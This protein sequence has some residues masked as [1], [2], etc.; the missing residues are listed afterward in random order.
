AEGSPAELTRA[1]AA[2]TVRFSAQPG[3]PVADLQAAL[4]AGARV[5]EPAA[6][7]YLVRAEVTPGLLAAITAWCAD[8]SVLADGLTVER[9]S[10][11]D[12]FLALTGTQSPADP[13]TAGNRTADQP[14][15]T[16]P[17]PARAGRR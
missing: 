11:E 3:L 17:R 8:R 10:L 2:G 15:S 14:P 16:G 5:S 1:G 9:R 6:G 4:P 12:V 7:D 13:A